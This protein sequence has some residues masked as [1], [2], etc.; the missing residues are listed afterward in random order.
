MVFRLRKLLYGLKQAA[1]QW[2]KKLRSVLEGI[3]YSRLRSDSSIN[4][5]LPKWRG[6]SIDDGL[7]GSPD[8]MDPDLVLRKLALEPESV[9][10]V[11]PKRT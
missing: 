10:T 6:K 1:R 4:I 2:N 7:K 9:E 5:L 11:P 8:Y 3:G